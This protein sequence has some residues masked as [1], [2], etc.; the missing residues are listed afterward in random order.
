MHKFLPCTFLL[1]RQA[2]VSIK[3]RKKIEAHAK[4]IVFVCVLK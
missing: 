2:E 3:A 1:A 4:N